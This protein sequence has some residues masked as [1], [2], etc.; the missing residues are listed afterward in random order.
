MKYE[1][2]AKIIDEVYNQWYLGEMVLGRV[3]RSTLTA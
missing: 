1:L 3:Q 2:G